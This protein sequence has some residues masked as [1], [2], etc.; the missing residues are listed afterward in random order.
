MGLTLNSDRFIKRQQVGLCIE[1]ENASF[2]VGSEF[3]HYL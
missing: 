3:M 1:D 2:E